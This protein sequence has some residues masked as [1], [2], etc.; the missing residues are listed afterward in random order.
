MAFYFEFRLPTG[1]MGVARIY[2]N[3]NGT[4]R[5][6]VMHQKTM[7]PRNNVHLAEWFGKYPGKPWEVSQFDPDDALEYCRHANKRWRKEAEELAAKS[8][9]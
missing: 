2:V 8:I 3:D 4:D 9:A 6:Q 7:Y 1:K 5:L